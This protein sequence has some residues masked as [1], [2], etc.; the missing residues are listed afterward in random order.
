MLE[1]RARFRVVLKIRSFTV[2]K[3]GLPPLEH[4]QIGLKISRLNGSIS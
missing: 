2:G 1:G 4:L 3:G